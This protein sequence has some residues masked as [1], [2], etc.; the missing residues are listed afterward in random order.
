[1]RVP[2]EWLRAGAT[3]EV[4]LPRNLACAACEGGGCDRCDRSGAVTLR[5]RGEPAE[6]VELTL[7]ETGGLDGSDAVILRIPDHGGL[8]KDGTGLPRGNLLLR[9]RGAP[10]AD[11][12]VARIR[13]SHPPGSGTPSVPVMSSVSPSEAAPPWQIIVLALCALAVL[14]AFWQV[15]KDLLP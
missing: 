15:L 1:V 7:P 14:Y 10:L 13:R 5:G 8:P 9:V 12:G 3:V 11:A 6:L 4:E 2:G